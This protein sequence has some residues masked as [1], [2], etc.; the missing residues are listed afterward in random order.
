MFCPE[1]APDPRHSRAVTGQPHQ[2]YP[3]W[4]A[5]SSVAISVT[6]GPMPTSCYARAA[7]ISL[8]VASLVTTGFAEVGKS[9]GKPVAVKLVIWPKRAGVVSGSD[10]E[11]R[12]ESQLKG[13]LS[14]LDEQG[15]LDLG[16]MDP[17]IHRFALSNIRMYAVDQDGGVQRMP[18]VN[19]TCS[20]Q[21]VVQPFQTYYL[22]VANTQDGQT[23]SCMI[24]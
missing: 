21:F 1:L 4:W 19:G 3:L 11:V 23:F 7:I 14:N 24:Q 18:N 10:M 20:G 12:V 17:G 2:I 15:L 8:A 9:T 13:Q 16:G 6:G 22:V 5:M